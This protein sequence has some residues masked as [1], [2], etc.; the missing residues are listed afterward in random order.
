MQG[1]YPGKRL[2]TD[3]M[4]ERFDYLHTYARTD[5]DE[6]ETGN[7]IAFLPDEQG[8]ENGTGYDAGRTAK[9]RNDNEELNPWKRLKRMRKT[10]SESIETHERMGRELHDGQHCQKQAGGHARHDIRES[11]CAHKASG[12]VGANAAVASSFQWSSTSA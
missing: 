10:G 1:T 12:R 7:E 2:R 5:K 11:L 8:Y 9:R 3:T 6:N 4:D